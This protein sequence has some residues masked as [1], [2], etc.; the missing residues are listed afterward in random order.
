MK[1][2]LNSVKIMSL[3]FIIKNNKFIKIV[4]KASYIIFLK[5]YLKDKDNLTTDKIK[6]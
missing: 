2:K 1:T 6:I 3:N 4:N 5:K